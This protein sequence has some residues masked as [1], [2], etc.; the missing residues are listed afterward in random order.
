MRNWIEHM[1][2]KY[3]ENMKQLALML[4]LV[5]REVCNCVQAQAV[6]RLDLENGTGLY[7]SVRERAKGRKTTVQA[8]LQSCINKRIPLRLVIVFPS[9][10]SILHTLDLQLQD[11]IHHLNT[12]SFRDSPQLG[13]SQCSLPTPSS[14][15]WPLPV[16]QMLL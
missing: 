2:T 11:I 5:E 6:N 1:S 8:Q 10:S 4:F 12:S 16:P 15:S 9:S 13:Y 3:N 14:L 7:G